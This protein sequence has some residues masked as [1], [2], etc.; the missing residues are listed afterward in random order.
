MGQVLL[1]TKRLRKAF[2]GVEAVSNVDLAVLEGDVH[3]LIGPNGAGKTTFFNLL[4]GSLRPDGGR[5]TFQVTDITGRAPHEI[6]RM[7]IARSFQRA[8]IFPKLSVFENIR[9]AA[10][11]REGKSFRLCP[12]AK[13]LAGSE[14][15]DLLETVGLSD[16]ADLPADSLAHGDKKRLELA[17]ALASRPK[18]LLLDE[19]TAGMSPDETKSTMAL[20]ARLARERGITVVFTEHDMTVVFGIARRL[21]VMHQGQIIADGSPAQVRESARVQQVYLGEAGW[22]WS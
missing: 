14:V 21:T 20:V 11:A 19:P 9:V 6:C 17:I 4:T 12:R 3:A 1:E 7:G 2:G 22:F 15:E 10:L 13:S 8:S 16:Q 18:L 5:I